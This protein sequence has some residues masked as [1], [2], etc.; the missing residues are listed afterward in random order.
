[1]TIKIYKLKIILIISLAL[2][3]AAVT[4]FLIHKRYP[5]IIQ[6][7]PKFAPHTPKNTP[8]STLN[9]KLIPHNSLNLP[10]PFTSQA[11]TGN[12]DTIHNEDCEEASVIMATEYFFGNTKAKL[13]ASYV[14]TQLTKLTDWEMSTFGYNL[15]INS[16]EVV[17]MIEANYSLHAKIITSYTEDDIKKELNQN[18]LALIPVNGQLIGNPNYKQ[19]GPKYHMLVIRG[20]NGDSII[21]NDPGTKNGQNY[22]YN[23]KTLY[24][25]NGNWDHKT[26]SVD[27]TQKNIIVVWK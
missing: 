14:E 24:N 7:F 15:D 16:S 25:A 1:M 22:I 21:T 2:A 5:I 12:W 4:L 23:F 19:P 13:D 18:H 26:E 11:P 8:S 27:L 20:Y 17:K 9:S 6:D 3:V 10:V